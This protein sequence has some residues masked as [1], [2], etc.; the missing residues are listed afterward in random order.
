M[1]RHKN[2]WTIALLCNIVQY[3]YVLVVD[4]IYTTGSTVE[5]VAKALVGMN[6]VSETIKKRKPCQVYFLS[7]CIGKGM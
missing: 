3:S 7:V 6:P 2:D 1:Y 5:A 4:D